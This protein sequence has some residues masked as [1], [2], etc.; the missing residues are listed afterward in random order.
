MLSITSTE[1]YIKVPAL[2]RPAKR[3]RLDS[4]KFRAKLFSLLPCK[5]NQMT[6]EQT[7]IRNNLKNS[8]PLYLG[9]NKWQHVANAGLSTQR[10]ATKPGTVN[11]ADP[12]KEKD[13]DYILF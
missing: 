1:P 11:T 7:I 10:K 5:E 13:S 8:Y 4:M 12:E 9:E 3:L 2:F 6:K